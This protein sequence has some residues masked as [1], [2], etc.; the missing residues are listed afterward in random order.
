MTQ[1]QG[2]WKHSIWSALTATIFLLSIL[3]CKS[4]ST[5][6]AGSTNPDPS[7]PDLTT[8]RIMP[9]G[10]SRVEGNRPEFESFRYELWKELKDQNLS[11]D[12]IGTQ[13][14]EA[15]Y[16]PYGEMEFDPDHEGWSGWTSA[17]IRESLMGW[18]EQTG[19]PDIVLLSSPG[20][21]D[22]LL[23]LSYDDA[24]ENVVAIV[25]LLQDDNPNVTILIEQMAP[26]HSDAMTQ[27]LAN[28][29][30]RFRG[31][32][33]TLS[34]EQ[35]TETSRIIVVDMATGFT[36]DYLADDVH[37]NEAGAEFIASR[38]ADVLMDLL[39]ME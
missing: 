18:L 17:D 27:E 34:E 20:G 39:E 23:G 2:T 11:F 32:V 3:S 14:D 31:D 13:Q 30:E 1:R 5:N 16:P 7:P 25:D 35:T 24:Y 19:P 12:L 21:N 4:N 29:M 26:A 15:T 22:A 8:Q 9:L 28:F 6:A 37:Y 38:Y 33:M 36:D 10:A